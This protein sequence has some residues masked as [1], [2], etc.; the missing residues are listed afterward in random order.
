MSLSRNQ[1][2]CFLFSGLSERTNLFL[3]NNRE[4]E[5]HVKVRLM[6]FSLYFNDFNLSKKPD[7]P[8]EI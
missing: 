1:A 2:F 4:Q 8:Q 3:E 7:Q 6:T 5:N